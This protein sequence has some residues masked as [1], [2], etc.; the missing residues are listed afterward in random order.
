M[1]YVSDKCADSDGP[2]A[3]ITV[4]PGG[5]FADIVA[6][7]GTKEIGDGINKVIGKKPAITA[8]KTTAWALTSARQGVR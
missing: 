8:V 4:P 7:K 6:L 2:F 5:R 3:D 1:K